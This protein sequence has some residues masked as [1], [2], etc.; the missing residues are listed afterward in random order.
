MDR[1]GE[2]TGLVRRESVEEK[3]QSA[4]WKVR[5]ISTTTAWPGDVLLLSCKRTQ[6][7]APFRR[8]GSMGL[9]GHPEPQYLEA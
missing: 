2:P 7:P 9:Q 1:A 8:Y 3:M 5:I 4:S 6:D